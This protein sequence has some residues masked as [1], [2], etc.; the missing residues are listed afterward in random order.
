MWKFYIEGMVVSTSH[1]CLKYHASITYILTGSN[2]RQFFP[3][4]YHLDH[5]RRHFHLCHALQKL[6]PRTTKMWMLTQF[7][8]LKTSIL[9]VAFLTYIFFSIFTTRCCRERTIT[10]KCLWNSDQCQ[11]FNRFSLNFYSN[12]RYTNYM[13]LI[14]IHFLQTVPIL[15]VR[16]KCYITI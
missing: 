10:M 4:V 6:S 5:C 9:E 16:I 11:Y 2:R 7:L 1:V 13:L 15:S 12:C 14:E 3:T 8:L